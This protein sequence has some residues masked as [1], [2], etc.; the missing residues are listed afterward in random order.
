MRPVTGTGIW[1]AGLRYGD[2]SEAAE[3]A[4]E[5][6]ELGYTALW[7]PDIGG[8]VFDAV[9]R[10]LAATRS[11]I[12]ATGILNLW[13]HT[14]EETAAEHARLKDAYGDR[15]LVGIGVSHA[16][17]IDSG[18]PGRY[19]R[20]LQAMASFLDGLDSASTPLEASSRVLAALG[21]KMLQVA[22]TRSAGAQP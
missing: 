7:V 13:M 3:A 16:M 8:E 6:E 20:P 12:V 10:L 11:T 17:L 4:G 2:P 19:R 15:F 5:L 1:S 22:R 14:A 18:S 9:Q 21:P